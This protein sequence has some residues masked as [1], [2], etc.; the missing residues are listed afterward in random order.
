M[1]GADSVPAHTVAERVGLVNLAMGHSHE[2]AAVGNGAAGVGNQG[3]G[4]VGTHGVETKDC[5]PVI[6]SASCTCAL[7]MVTIIKLRILNAA[8]N[9]LMRCSVVIESE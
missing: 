7:A 6:G 2:A 4:V 9:I 1:P 5:G 3:A 8:G